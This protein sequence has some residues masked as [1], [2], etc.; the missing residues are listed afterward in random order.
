CIHVIRAMPGPIRRNRSTGRGRWAR[1]AATCASAPA[2]WQSMHRS[3]AAPVTTSWRDRDPSLATPTAS[4]TATSALTSTSQCEARPPLLAAVAVFQNGPP[5]PCP[6][7]DAVQPCS[8]TA[9]DPV[10][11][12]GDLEQR[13]VAGPGETMLRPAQLDLRRPGEGQF[14]YL[15]RTG[16]LHRC[17]GVARRQKRSLDVIAAGL[18][19]E[20]RHG[21]GPHLIV[22]AGNL[23]RGGRVQADLVLRPMHPHPATRTGQANLV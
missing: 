9:L 14:Q 6:P 22:D 15:V 8:L 18:H 23:Q 11:D 17:L 3:A 19:R 5:V 7:A 1:R 21:P 20:L 10:I 16:D 2:A 13:L 12:P 4:P